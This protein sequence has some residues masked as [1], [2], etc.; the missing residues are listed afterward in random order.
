MPFSVQVAGKQGH[1]DAAGRTPGAD[2]G[3][4]AHPATRLHFALPGRPTSLAFDGHL[5]GGASAGKV[6]QAGVPAPSRCGAA[7]RSTPP[8]SAS[9]GW[10]PG[11]PSPSRVPA[12]L[13]APRRLRRE[14]DPRRLRERR[15]GRRLRRP[16][17]GGRLGSASRGTRSTCRSTGRRHGTRVAAHELEIRFRSGGAMLAG[18]LTVTR[19][20]RAVTRGGDRS[21]LRPDS[22]HRRLR[23]RGLLRQPRLRRPHVRQARDR[24]VG[25]PLPGRRGE[26]GERRHVRARR[27]GCRAPR[28]PS[29]R[30]S[31]ASAS[32]SRVR[33]RPA[34]SCRSPRRASRRQVPRPRLGADGDRGRAADVPGPDD[35]GRDDAERRRLRTILAAGATGRP[36]RLRPAARRSASSRS[37]RSGSRATSTS[38]CRPRLCVERRRR[39]PD[40][41]SRSRL[42][43]ADHFLIESEH[44][45]NARGA[46]LA[47][48]R[49]RRLPRAR[50]LARP[51][52]GLRWT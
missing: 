4:R 45:L 1:G 40:A 41:T 52:H 35:R 19:R 3:R 15:R 7:R 39:A 34:G 12:R 42:P 14:R 49:R 38:T 30:R 51:A 36:E 32:G 2:H 9:T 47:P 46:A 25:R 11:T 28:S 24:S 20:R 16:G 48:L 27:R 17:S 18:T 21:R 8:G 31:T 26:P 23:L 44:G 50:L 33:A 5:R 37:R 29:S 43:G 13:A 6:K 22:P 10:T